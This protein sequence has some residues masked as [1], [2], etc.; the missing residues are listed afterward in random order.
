MVPLFRRFR[1]CLLTHRLLRLRRR[2]FD[3]P[4]RLVLLFQPLALWDL[5]VHQL[6]ALRFLLGRLP[7]RPLLIL[8]LTL[9]LLHSLR[10]RFRF[11]SPLLQSNRQGEAQRLDS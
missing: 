3:W 1:H 6:V 11:L 9:I 5:L 7:R 4:H 8:R 10:L 2:R